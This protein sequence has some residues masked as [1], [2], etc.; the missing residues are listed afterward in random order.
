MVSETEVVCLYGDDAAVS[1]TVALIAD[2]H[3]NLA[4]LDALLDALRAEPPDQIVCLGDVAATGQQPREVVRRLRDL[5][6]PM[7]M[8]NADA[9]LLDVSPP[10]PETDEDARRIADI[11]RWCVAKLD[12]ADRAFLASFQPTVEISFVEER[13]L[14]CWHGSPRNYDDVMSATTSNDEL[15]S[16]IVGHDATIIAGGHTHIRMLRA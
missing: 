4:A 1:M 13:R 3:G 5:G 12:D 14:L 6:C 8:S 7:V 2:I 10:T 9:E 11:S 16:M 15:D